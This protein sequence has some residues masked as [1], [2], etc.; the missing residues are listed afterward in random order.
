MQ[1]KIKDMTQKLHTLLMLKP[2]GL[3][4]WPHLVA[5]EKCN[6]WVGGH[7][8]KLKIQP[9]GKREG[10]GYWGTTSKLCYNV[11]WKN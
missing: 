4:I 11:Y 6:H 9:H 7:I 1:G 3:I 5:T 2:I 8:P 10:T